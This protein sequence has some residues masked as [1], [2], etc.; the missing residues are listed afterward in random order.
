M[1]SGN[2]GAGVGV[3][4][5]TSKCLENTFKCLNNKAHNVC[6]PYLCYVLRTFYNNLSSHFLLSSCFCY[7]VE[8]F[9]SGSVRLGQFYFG[10]YSIYI[11]C[12]SYILK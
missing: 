1:P 11:A 2:P 8:Q 7:N 12:H 9:N 4:P 3:P 10:K 5:Q 6:K